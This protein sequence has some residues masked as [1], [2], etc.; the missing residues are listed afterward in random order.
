MPTAIETQSRRPRFQRTLDRPTLQ[1]TPRDIEILRAVT[2]HRFLRSASIALLIDG[3]AKKIIE[4]VGQLYYAGYLERPPAQLEYYRAGGGSSCIVY[5]IANRGA[6][7]LIEHDGREAADVDWSRKNTQATRRF[8]LHTLAVADVAVA[9]AL[10]TRE[11]PTFS[12]QHLNQLI[13]LMPPA[14]RAL[15][16][17][18][19]WR[20]KVKHNNQPLVEVGVVPDLAFAVTYEDGGRRCFLVECDRGTMPVERETLKQ[21]SIVKKLLAYETGRKQR[22][23]HKQFSWQNFRVLVI[24][25]TPERAANIR[26]AIMRNPTLKASPLFLVADKPNLDIADILKHHWLDAYGKTHTLV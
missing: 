23:H 14:T 2:T 3:P 16:Q 1:L 18:L 17:P 10:A 12:L 26:A 9:L 15:R 6:Q 24:T 25:N 4:R 5:A 7:V 22:L 21:T 20:V 11:Q 8:I 13:A 19:K